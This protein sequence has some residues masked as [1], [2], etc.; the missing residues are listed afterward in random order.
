MSRDLRHGE[1][2]GHRPGA[3]CGPRVVD[4]CRLSDDWLQ[5]GRFGCRRW[6]G[7]SAG[8]D[9]VG[10]DDDLGE[11]VDCDDGGEAEKARQIVLGYDQNERTALLS[12]LESL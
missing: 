1:A 6:C 11:F 9:A 10:D 7:D 3:S 2:P 5:A 12:F 8:A 4:L